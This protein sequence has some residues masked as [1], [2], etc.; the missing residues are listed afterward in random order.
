MIL[1]NKQQQA[2]DTMSRNYKMNEP[3]TVVSG[4]AG[5]GKSTIIRY[6]IEQNNLMDK[7]RFVTFTGKASL[8]LQQKGLAATTIHKLIYNTYKNYKTGKFY[9]RLKKE[10]DEDIDLIVIDEVSMVPL[11]LLQDLL[12]FG[13]RIVALGDSGQLEPIGEDNGLLKNPHIFL[14]EIHRQAEDNSIIRLSMMARNNQPI[15]LINDDPNVKVLRR[16]D[17]TVGMMQWADQILCSKNATRKNINDEMREA[18]GFSGVLPVK[19]DKVICLHNY[20]DFLNEDDY[21]LINGT[22]GNV[23]NC[24]MGKD[25][26]IL[27][28]RCIIDFKA[29]YTPYEWY[30]VEV[31]SNIFRG[32]APMNVNPK[33][34][35]MVYQFDFGYAITIHKA[36]GS[37]YENVLIYE[38]YLKSANHARLLY[39][40]I[41]RASEKL[42]LIKAE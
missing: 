10:L 31:D 1:T 25:G 33:H 16:Q 27:G 2:L 26:N 35:Q 14:D 12:T 15:P 39:T 22:V 34:K 21:P 8:V 11:K 37:S 30:G 42:I 19:G 41:T 13:V 4:F 5:V 6:F 20:W 23:S 3:I 29:D 32:F 9:F 7:T 17:L 28:Q 36:Q 38:E 24:F 18:L 40:A